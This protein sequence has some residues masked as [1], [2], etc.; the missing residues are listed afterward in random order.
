[1]IL[2]LPSVWTGLKLACLAVF[3]AF[4]LAPLLTLFVHSVIPPGGGLTLSGYAEFFS[5]PR[6]VESLTN[7]LLLGV[8]TTVGA[9][10]IGLP[11]AFAVA[12]YDFPF[13][14]L[15]AVLPLVTFV[16]PDIIVTQ[17]WLMVLGNNGIVTNIV[18][19]QFGVALPSIYG[20]T[21]LTLVMV[22]QHYGYAYLYR[23]LRRFAA[24][25]PRW[26]M[27]AEHSAHRRCGF[28]ARSRCGC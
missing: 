28:T 26:R 18:W 13:K 9:L 25:M 27:P 15:L 7:S 23:S 6:H 19:R 14:S 3:A 4:V 20:W 5:T 11:L 12:R 22:L 10:A 24:S 1:M 16:V 2:R 8:V 21:G 17:A